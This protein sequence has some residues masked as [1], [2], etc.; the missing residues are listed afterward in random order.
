MTGQSIRTRTWLPA[1]LPIAVLT[2]ITTSVLA[3]GDL[4][5]SRS[6]DNGFLSDT[7]PLTL[8]KSTQIERQ[9][10]PLQFRI[11][12]D[13]PSNNGISPGYALNLP[14]LRLDILL[15]RMEQIVISG[16][17]FYSTGSH[18]LYANL[19]LESTSASLTDPNVYGTLSL[20]PV[21]PGKVKEI[22]PY[23]IYSG[24]IENGCIGSPPAVFEMTLHSSVYKGSTPSPTLASVTLHDEATGNGYYQFNHTIRAEDDAGNVSDFVFSGSAEATCN[25]TLS[26]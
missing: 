21:G 11:A 12:N 5:I 7:R 23:P 25:A 3:T 18:P 1:L 17:G 24:I 16:E 8:S 14:N 9:H 2:L 6:H 19:D 20:A 4:L 15:T 13:A 26:F 22:P 10:Q